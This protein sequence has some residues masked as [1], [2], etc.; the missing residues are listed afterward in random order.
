M[1]KFNQEGGRSVYRYYKILM[2]KIGE[3]TNK[4]KII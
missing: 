4:W 3:D 1:N 2:T